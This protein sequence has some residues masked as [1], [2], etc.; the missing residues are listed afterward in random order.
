MSERRHPEPSPESDYTQDPDLLES[1]RTLGRSPI[2][3]EEAGA[4]RAVETDAHL[5]HCQGCGH[6]ILWGETIH[7]QRLAVE[8][9]Q[10]TYVVVW[11][12]RE[13]HPRFLPSR[14]YVAHWCPEGATHAGLPDVSARAGRAH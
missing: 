11:Q 1:D 3:Q 8:P 2:Y 13:Q 14:G 6:L 12:P 7:G 9:E 5:V 4:K 10:Q